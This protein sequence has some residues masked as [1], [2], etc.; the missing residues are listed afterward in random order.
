MPFNTHLNMKQDNTKKWLKKKKKK[1]KEGEE[2]FFAMR[3]F[4]ADHKTR[5]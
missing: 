3:Y 5:S 2:G 4:A 1:K